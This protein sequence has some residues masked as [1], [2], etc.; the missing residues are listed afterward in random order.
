M[1]EYRIR[2]DPLVVDHKLEFMFAYRNVRLRG[3]LTS[4]SVS[5]SSWQALQ[6]ETGPLG[7]HTCL[8]FKRDLLYRQKRP[9]NTTHTCLTV[10]LTHTQKRPTLIYR[11]KRPT[12]TTHTCLTL[13]DTLLCVP[14]SA[15]KL[16]PCRP[17]KQ[18]ATILSCAFAHAEWSS[19]I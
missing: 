5:K 18:Q 19:R 1:D 10:T 14:N 13:E 8:T 7:G 2:R 11:Q 4:H 15:V 3:T 12:N 16:L 9:T 6:E 17:R